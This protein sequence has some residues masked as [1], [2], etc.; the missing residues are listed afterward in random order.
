MIHANL[1]FGSN[2][3]IEEKKLRQ[4][5]DIALSLVDK[6]KLKRESI[7]TMDNL[8]TSLSL[9]SKFTEMG[10]YDL[11]KIGEKRLLSGENWASKAS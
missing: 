8:F 1:Y 3:N 2:T 6:C 9:L 11:G 4:E 5:S 7:V 10:I